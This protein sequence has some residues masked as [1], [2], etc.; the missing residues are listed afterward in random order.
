M[1][2]VFGV[3]G[4]LGRS[5]LEESRLSG[6]PLI[7]HTRDQT[8]INDGDAV[9][10]AI[11][12]TR[13][14]LVVNAAAYTAVDR[15]E[16]EAAAAEMVN[17]QGAAIV[18]SVSA[19]ADIPMV[20]VSTDYVFDGTKAGAYV[21]SDPVAPIGAYGRSKA[22]GEAAVRQT[23]P[24]H[25]ILRTSWLYGHFGQNFLKTVLRLA[26]ARSELRI[27]AD[28]RGCPTSTAELARA[29]LRVAHHMA[30]ADVAYGTYHFGGTGET[31]WHGFASEIVNCQALF[32]GRRPIVTP[33]ATADY[34]TAAR[35][36][37]NSVLD[38]SRFGL[39]F[40][41]RAEP[42]QAAVRTAVHRLHSLEIAA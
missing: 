4:Q 30:G 6:V 29:I 35:R 37:A 10:R 38:S 28:Q 40:G 1:I 2:L 42:W 14:A 21:E 32:T 16:S 17:A 20:Q 39:A 12:V 13:P 15:A 27:V 5:L 22:N 9:L 33:I 26:D 24:R 41:Y 36:P 3:G 18:A 25:I 11:G 7:G 23:N 34:P 8:D 19:A 31:T